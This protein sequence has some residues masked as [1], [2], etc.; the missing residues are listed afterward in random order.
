MHSD[1]QSSYAGRQVITA[2]WAGNALFAVTAA[3]AAAGVDAFDIPA[4]AVALLLFLAGIVVWVASYVRAVVRNVNG[5]AVTV[6]RMFLWQGNVPRAVTWQLYGSLAVCI[7]I[8]AGTASAEPFGTLVPM[9]P[10]GLVGLWG[11]RYGTFPP[12]T[13]LNPRRR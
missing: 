5:E 11:A 13:D 1:E 4:I 2:S 6:P 10:L 3:P 12:R 8:V 9:Y 7:L